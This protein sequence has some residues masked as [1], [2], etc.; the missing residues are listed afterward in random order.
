MKILTEINERIFNPLEP[1]NLINKIANT[2]VLTT[3]KTL[4][5]YIAY[6]HENFVIK[7]QQFEIY[8]VR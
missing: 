4:K 1:S 2:S 5:I 7:K 8:I 6:P 3:F